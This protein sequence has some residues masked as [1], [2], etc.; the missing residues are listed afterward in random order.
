[1]VEHGIAKYS[2]LVN[3]V[4]TTFRQGHDACHET[5]ESPCDGRVTCSGTRL[6]ASINVLVVRQLPLVGQLLLV[7]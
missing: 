7:R 6:W 5:V 1:M 4:K 3:V 2:W